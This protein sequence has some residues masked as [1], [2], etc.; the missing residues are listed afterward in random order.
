ML[1]LVTTCLVSLFLFSSCNTTAQFQKSFDNNQGVL[2]IPL[3]YKKNPETPSDIAQLINHKLSLVIVNVETK[4]KVTKTVTM[5]LNNNYVVS[6]GFAPGNYEVVES[7]YLKGVEKEHK[8]EES[9][10]FTIKD[11]EFT[12]LPDALHYSVYRDQIGDYWLTKRFLKFKYSDRK[13]LQETLESMMP[14]SVPE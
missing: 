1:K 2:V 4:S 5:S 3:N 8:S 14:T 7:Y 9:I 6:N 10:M 11:G 12:V 13:A